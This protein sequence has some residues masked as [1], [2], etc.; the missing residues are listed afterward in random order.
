MIHRRRYTSRRHQR[1]GSVLVEVAATVPILFAFF[2]FLWEFSRAEM[3]RQAA[4]TACYE[5]AREG[6]VAGGTSAEVMA[7]SQGILD[8]AGIRNATIVVTPRVIDPT[9]QSV[10]VRVTVPLNNNAITT[11][12]FFKDKQINS[13]ITLIR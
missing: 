5:G 4:A 7:V 3:I 12:C 6:T 2:G 10:Q 8:A 1:R 9:T 13:D 11:P